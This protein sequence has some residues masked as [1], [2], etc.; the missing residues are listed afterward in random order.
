V[1]WSHAIN[2]TRPNRLRLE[3]EAVQEILSFGKWILVS[4]AMMFL[5]TQSDRFL[6]GKLFTMT[7]FGIY[8]IAANLSELPK[9]I[10]TRL[11]SKVLFPLITKYSCSSHEELRAALRSSRA[12][13]LLV[14][15]PLLA[16][17]SCFGDII[18]RIIYDQRY[19]AVGWIFPIIGLG[20]WPLILITTIDI[21][22]LSIGK[23]IYS[24]MG[25]LAKFLYMVIFIPLSFKL[26][27]VFGAILVVALNDI[28]SFIIINYG[29]A[30]EKL[31][32]IKQ[33]AWTTLIL[34]G[35][36]GVLLLIRFF[37]GMGLPGQAAFLA[38]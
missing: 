29:L 25:N 34:L 24:A 26:G 4:T 33:D 23:P 1:I 12:K 19:S 10:I 14:M 27:G 18:V 36:T 22:L 28:P 16:V 21:S 35:T 3:K 7:W 32:L 6:L 31:S 8:S 15:A 11:S 5:A 20:M 13:I 9:Q 30:K 37:A 38:R 17:V 2:T